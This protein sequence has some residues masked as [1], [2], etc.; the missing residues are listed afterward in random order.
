VRVV[1]VVLK[2]RVLMTHSGFGSKCLPATHSECSDRSPKNAC[3]YDSQWV[4]V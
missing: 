2:M 1:T 3:T 4:W